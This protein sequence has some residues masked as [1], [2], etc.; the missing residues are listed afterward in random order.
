MKTQIS[1]DSHQ[2]NRRYNGVY[3]QQGRMIT[4]ADW[5]ELVDIIKRELSSSLTDIVGNGAPREGGVRIV[6]DGS[7]VKIVPGH[8]YVDGIR[9]EV[10]GDHAASIGFDEQADYPGLAAL[11]TSMNG[12]IYADVWERTVISLED[13]LLVDP[14][15]YGA[16]TTGRTEVMAQIKW[17]PL[18]DEEGGSGEC[19]SPLCDLANMPSKGNATF[20]IDLR[21][22]AGF[23]DPCDPCEKEVEYHA[24]TGNYLFRLEV[25]DVTHDP[26]TGNPVS[27][28]LK[29]SSE[30][31]AEHY[32]IDPAPP[33]H[34]TQGNWI[35]E[36]YRSNSE[37]HMGLHL[38]T[39]FTPERP[40][41]V[42]EYEVPLAIQGLSDA[43]KAEYMTRRWDGWCRLNYAD[44]NWI[45]EEGGVHRGVD[46]ITPDMVVEGDGI[47][48]ASWSDGKLTLSLDMLKLELGVAGKQFLAGDYW[49]ALVR[50]NV[51]AGDRVRVLSE[52]PLGVRHHYLKLA[53]LNGSVLVTPEN[54][55][56][57]ALSF[58]TMANLTADR[59]GYDPASAITQWNTINRGSGFPQDLQRAMD[60][61]AKN[62]NAGSLLMDKGG[63]LASLLDNTDVV[64][65]QDALNLIANKLFGQGCS[66]TIGPGATY[67]TLE[68]AISNLPGTDRINLCFLPGEHFV[69]SAVNIH[70]KKSIKITGAGSRSSVLK[71]RS[72]IS[73]QANEIVLRDIGFDA[74]DNP[75]GLIL[76]GESVVTEQCHANRELRGFHN[77]WAKSFGG[78]V[79]FQ[80]FNTSLV[81]IDPSGNYVMMG[82]FQGTMDFGEGAVGV[83][84]KWYFFILKISTEGTLLWYKIVDAGDTDE[85]NSLT[86]DSTGKIYLAGILKQNSEI[87]FGNNENTIM[88]NSGLDSTTFI[89]KLSSD[90]E[91]L[92]SKNFIVNTQVSA[93]SITVDLDDNVILSGS[94]LNTAN[95]DGHSLENNQ[96]KADIFLIK[97]NSE[98]NSGDENFNP[99]RVSFGGTDGCYNRGIV[100]D[101]ENNIVLT[102]YFKDTLNFGG[103]DDELAS[104]GNSD[105]YLTKL[106]SSGN[107]LW[108]TS[109][110]GSTEWIPYSIALDNNG[111]LVVSGLFENQNDG[112]PS[113]FHIFIAMFS[114]D[115]DLLWMLNFEGGKDNRGL[116]VSFNQTD[117]ILLTGF[118]TDRIY[119]GDTELVSGGNNDIFITKISST[120]EVMWARS[121]GGAGSDGTWSIA[122]GLYDEILLMGA[123]QNTI[124]FGSGNLSATSGTQSLFVAKFA[125]PE[126]ESLPALVRV[127]EPALQKSHLHFTG[128][129]IRATINE[130]GGSVEGPPD[131]LMVMIRCFLMRS[132]MLPETMRG[133]PS[134]WIILIM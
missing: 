51:V 33:A 8:L 132:E 108:S 13:A 17:R 120:G 1:R 115:G 114:G 128:N 52:E 11:T 96:A 119:I 46:L 69:S 48:N 15:L 60:N 53:M 19:P 43:Q 70:N 104:N 106:D 40:E 27:V 50:D 12:V 75:A 77:I 88:T 10:P 113:S 99:L 3:Q 122:S 67:E 34:F 9:A 86:V 131:S 123:F 39:D 4:D 129:Q 105:V 49:L 58:P 74:N 83:P 31:G 98:L 95:F 93:L 42:D 22:S 41:L 28:V 76:Q 121:F 125:P 112:M 38:T 110:G 78:V 37:K 36:Y 54:V 25:H 45:L 16:D 84:D 107:H 124:N 18:T 130:S 109:F 21:D 59:V 61:I 87:N 90:G 23:S 100:V 92:L 55:E 6:L 24:N 101:A 5:N 81:A 85:L 91:Y 71:I 134:P 94:F 133:D 56:K 79:A 82:K 73:L 57:R 2:Q 116:S 103:V 68:E 30:N 47:S 126:Y 44:G 111:N 29:W 80:M 65:T 89:V 64:T 118:F 35:Y 127:V 97:F 7:V 117:D 32:H 14:A 63:T 62:L 20:H 102:G 72:D 26:V 66:I